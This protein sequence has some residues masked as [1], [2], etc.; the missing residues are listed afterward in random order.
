M[1]L[2]KLHG[3][4][5]KALGVSEQTLNN[6]YNIKGVLSALEANFN[7]FKKYME[8]NATTPF[9]LIVNRKKA[10]DKSSV[11]IYTLKPGDTVDIVPAIYGSGDDWGSWATIIIGIILIYLSWGTNPTG[12][13]MVGMGMGI[14]MVMSGVSQLLFKPEVIEPSTY[15]TGDKTL[16]NY[17]FNGAVNLTSQGNAV[18]VGYGMLRV[19]SQVIGAGLYATNI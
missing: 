9:K 13:Q 8:A 7:G 10:L 6:C 1:I 3:S 12:W 4:L 18:P 15:E 11:S 5:K 14:N 17:A 2:V 16:S 19:G